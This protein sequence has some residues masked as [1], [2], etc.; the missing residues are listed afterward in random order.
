MIFTAHSYILAC[1]NAS[2]GH[3]ANNLCAFLQSICAEWYLAEDPMD[4]TQ[5]L[6]VAVATVKA[7]DQD[8]LFCPYVA[9]LH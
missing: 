4:N 6:V 9:I 2:Q 5:N 1:C 8:P 3:S 7:V